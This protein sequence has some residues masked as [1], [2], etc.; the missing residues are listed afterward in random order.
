MGI[1][2]KNEFEG[3][4]KEQQ[5]EAYRLKLKSSLYE[6]CKFLGY[7]D[8]NVRTH[9]EIISCLE[10]PYLRKLL[11]VPRGTFKSSIAAQAYPIWKLI[12]NPNERILIDSEIY[13]NAVTYLRA[14]KSH[15]KSP[16]FI[17]LFGDICGDLWQEG[18]ITITTRTENHR[19]A[20]ITC[21]GVATTKV[22]QHYTT[23]IGDDYNSRD[24]SKTRELAQSVIDH[25]RYNLNILEP[26]GEY[27][28]IGTRYS[29][30]DLIGFILR[31]VLGESKLAEGDL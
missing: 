15:L 16:E 1:I 5:K 6:T 9:G 8:V 30:D 4:N 13:S 22:G 27:V 12:R 14:I 28:I 2:T 29:E 10:S 17:S 26:G 24:N 18:A 25:F 11:T 31:D 3:L 21:G 20:S 19:E 23:I 7:K